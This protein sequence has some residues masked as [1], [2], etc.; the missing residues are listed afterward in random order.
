M[1]TK[2]DYRKTFSRGARAAWHFNPDC[3]EYPTQIYIVRGDAPPA[4]E[5]CPMCADPA[6]RRVQKRGTA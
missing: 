1:N 6:D 4:N 5:L 3:P 2:I